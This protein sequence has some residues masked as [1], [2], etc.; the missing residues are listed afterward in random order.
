MTTVLRLAELLAARL[1]H[2]LSGPLGTLAGT[3]ELAGEDPA[4]AGEALTLASASAAALAA[5]LRLVRAAWSGD[6]APMRCGQIETLLAGLPPSRRLRIDLSGIDPEPEFP[7]AAARLLINALMLGAESLP[8]GGVLSGHGSP[9]GEVILTLA[10]PGAAWPPGFAACLVDP[11]QAWAALSGPRA[12]QMPLTA[13]IAHAAGLRARL[14]LGGPVTAG[15]PP[16]LLA[17][18]G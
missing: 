3:I 9:A 12:L 1:C 18:A 10:G 4:L 6:H 5:R 8:A 15:P 13:L 14:L 2:D 7:P 11:E 17:C 16:L